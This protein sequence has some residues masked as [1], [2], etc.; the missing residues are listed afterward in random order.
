MPK[1]AALRGPGRHPKDI[2][3][4]REC[5]ARAQFIHLPKLGVRA[6]TVAPTLLP[7]CNACNIWAVAILLLA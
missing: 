1:T 6:V 2:V 3:S 4:R 7:R 5:V